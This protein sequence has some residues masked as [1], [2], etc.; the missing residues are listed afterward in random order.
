VLMMARPTTIAGVTA[1]LEYL[2]SP[3]EL[4]EPNS[5]TAGEDILG[6]WNGVLADLADVLRNII[7]RGQA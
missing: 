5:R 2:D 4:D 1:L 7:E 3:E 6:E